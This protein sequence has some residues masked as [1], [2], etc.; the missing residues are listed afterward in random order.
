[1]NKTSGAKTF[2][3][4]FP[5]GTWV[6]MADWNQTVQGQDDMYMLDATVNYTQVHLAPASVIPFQNNSDM[7]V[8]TTADLLKKPISLVI[9]RDQN[10]QANGQLFLDTGLLISEMDDQTYEYYNF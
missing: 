7:M 8:N 1:M 2:K 9:N 3:S 10:G 5:K 6:S 4:Y